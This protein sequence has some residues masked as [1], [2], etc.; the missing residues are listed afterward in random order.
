MKHIKES[1][2]AQTVIMIQVENEIGMLTEARERTA[3]ADKAFN[4]IGAS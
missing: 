1:D 3:D 4:S 2:K